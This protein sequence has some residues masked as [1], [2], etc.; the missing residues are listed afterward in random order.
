M[1][2][3]ADELGRCG[4][5]AGQMVSDILRLGVEEWQQ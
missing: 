5:C 1:H 2:G 3:V 4:D